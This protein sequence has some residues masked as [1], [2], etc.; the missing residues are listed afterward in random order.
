MACPLRVGR[1][2]REGRNLLQSPA[3]GRPMPLIPLTRSRVSE[4]CTGFG[5]G[6]IGSFKWRCYEYTT[7]PKISGILP[8]CQAFPLYLLAAHSTV[9]EPRLRCAAVSSLGLSS[10]P[11]APSGR[12]VPDTRIRVVEKRQIPPAVI[13]LGIL[14]LS[15]SRSEARVR[16][17]SRHTFCL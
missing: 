5:K 1:Q 14:I 15:F 8:R 3:L 6:D 11:A 10:R 16:F 2:V 13:A 7:R 4:W 9:L 12:A 17:R